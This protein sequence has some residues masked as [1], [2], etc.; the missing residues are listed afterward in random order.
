MLGKS[1]TGT[2]VEG[3][4]VTD[5][6]WATTT[7][8][9]NNGWWKVENTLPVALAEAAQFSLSFRPNTNGHWDVQN[10]ALTDLTP[11]DVNLVSI[12]VPAAV[13][14]VKN[15][16]AKTAAALGLPATVALTTDGAA[17]SGNVTW[18]VAASSY[19]AAVITAQTFNVAGT[20]ALPATVTNTNS[21]ALTTTISVT[22]DAPA[23][24]AYNDDFATAT[25]GHFTVTPATA[26][27][28]RAAVSWYSNFVATKGWQN[29]ANN[30]L[31]T[32]GSN[33][34][35]FDYGFSPTAVITTS[36]D[37]VLDT[38][39]D[40]IT[41]A[42]AGDAM[43][44][45]IFSAKVVPGKTYSVKFDA[46][47]SGATS[48]ALLVRD[49][50][51][52]SSVKSND[53]V[54]NITFEKGYSQRTNTNGSNYFTGS[55]VTDATKTIELI[56][57][58]PATFA[59]AG[60]DHAADPNALPLPIP[61]VTGCD[62]TYNVNG[63][64][65]MLANFN[66]SLEV[67]N[68]TM[69]ETSALPT[70]SVGQML[71]VDDIPAIDAKFFKKDWFYA[72]TNPLTLMTQSNYNGP[73]LTDEQY[74]AIIANNITLETGIL[75]T[76][77]KAMVINAKAIYDAGIVYNGTT[78]I[79]QIGFPAKVKPSTQYKVSFIGKGRHAA[80]AGHYP[81]ID[82]DVQLLNDS[83]TIGGR[84]MLINENKWDWPREELANGFFKFS[85]TFTTDSACN[86]VTL[87]IRPSCGIHQMF[88]LLTTFLIM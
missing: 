68:L 32:D 63:Y 31:A 19:D 26:T 17:A 25:A 57:T 65:L 64:T 55:P 81:G 8:N 74:I 38:A 24:L 23:A 82:V 85:Y 70:L 53:Q 49:G 27:G 78:Y 30:G 84:A 83:Y 42:K 4:L 52:S 14:G 76:T 20:V 3:V 50:W 39:N 10:I 28:T 18:N 16:V 43:N 34:W 61:A 29:P 12:P 35:T 22:V 77:G 69:A 54:N 59:V 80:V 37:V 66:G 87:N 60:A 33:P 40:K 67:S 11:S 62:G 72:T 48:T 45:M 13:T 58:V 73:A 51:A 1:A 15:G 56:F 9:L 7:T 71:N 44:A 21:V 5:I 88:L 6:T 46:K 41:I 47:I 79:A 75:G 86:A 36:A 2:S